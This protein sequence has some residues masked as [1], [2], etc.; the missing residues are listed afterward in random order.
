[1]TPYSHDKCSLE[2]FL[3][4]RKQSP[5]LP[6]QR[7]IGAQGRA[8]G[9]GHWGSQAHQHTSLGPE[10]LYYSHPGGWPGLHK[11]KTAGAW[12]V[13]LTIH[14]GRSMPHT[15]TPFSTGRVRC[16][17][18]NTTLPSGS[19]N[20]DSPNSHQDQSPVPSNLRTWTKLKS[21]P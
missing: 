4:V 12:G 5:V 6:E 1:M 18:R 7:K 21:L 20:L 9:G 19:Q 11:A 10:L 16:H 3:V 15:G 8:W 17:Y 13:L 2:P 14:L